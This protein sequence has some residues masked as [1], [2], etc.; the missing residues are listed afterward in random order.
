[1]PTAPISLALQDRGLPIVSFM[2]FPLD[3]PFGTPR[4]ARRRLRRSETVRSF[5]LHDSRKY[6]LSSGTSRTLPE[7]GVPRQEAQRRHDGRSGFQRHSGLSCPRG[8]GEAA[9]R[10][11]RR[12][13]AIALTLVI[14]VVGS[15]LF[16]LLSPWWWTPI[17]S[18]WSYID[19]T[20]VDHLLDHRLR[21]RGGGPVHG[22]LRLPLPASRGSPRRLRAREPAAEALADGRSPRSESRRC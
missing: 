10:R 12:A 14:V 2:T 4:S 7:A 22:L 1:M 11:G 20:L 21:V 3:V 13:M 15:V 8:F 9:N 5:G 17:A 6:R 18:N 19:H 16:H